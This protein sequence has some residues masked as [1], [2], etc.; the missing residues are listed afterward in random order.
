VR[1]AIGDNLLTH[2]FASNLMRLNKSFIVLRGLK[3]MKER[4]RA[5]QKLSRYIH[6]SIL[7]DNANVWIAQA[8]G[9]A[10]AGYDKTNSAVI[11]MFSL[12]KPKPVLYSDYIN[13]LNIVPVAISYELDPTDVSKARE[14]YAVASEGS[15]K[16]RKHE[17]MNS[18]AK[19]MTG[20]K[21]RVHIEFG[22]VLQGDFEKDADVAKAIDDQIYKL[23]RP[24]E[25]N[26]WAEAQLNGES[27]ARANVA[28]ESLA[29]RCEKLNDQVKPFLLKQYANGMR[30]KQNKGPL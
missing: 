23:F 22:D 8:E 17:D 29:A 1:I 10:K 11:G 20:W 5:A 18:I 24:F 28:V 25:T 7:E 19:G 4:L 26:E 3:G 27:I 13:E 12:S 2:A 14:L 16:K 9:R 21:G 6:F 15:Y 30:M